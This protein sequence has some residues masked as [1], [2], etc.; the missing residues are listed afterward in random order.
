MSRNRAG[1]VVE[2][3]EMASLLYLDVH[4]E[5]HATIGIVTEEN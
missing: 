2:Y 1:Y 4:A 5:C 3:G